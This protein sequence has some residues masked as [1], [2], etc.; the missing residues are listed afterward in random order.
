MLEWALA[1]FVLKNGHHA[2][3]F[4]CYDEIEL[5]AQNVWN[6]SRLYISLV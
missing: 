5:C 1:R 3:M 2:K 4:V 6:H